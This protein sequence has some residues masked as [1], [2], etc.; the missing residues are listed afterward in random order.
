MTKA[1]CLSL[2]L[3]TSFLFGCQEKV[4]KVVA[5]PEN[6]PK[7]SRLYLAG[8][9]NY[10]DPTDPSFELLPDGKGNYITKLP[11]GW[12]TV[13][14]KVTRGDW[15][16]VE[17]N[18]CGYYISNRTIE[19]TKSDTIN[20]GIESW[21]DLEP[22][23]C[24]RVTIKLNPPKNTKPNEKIYITGSFNNWQ[25]SEQYLLK[26]GKDGKFY[27][28]LRKFKP[29]IEFKFSKGS[30]DSEELNTIGNTVENHRFTFG[31]KDTFNVDVPLWKNALG[32][33][34][35]YV[36]ITVKAPASTKPSEDVYIAGNFNNW[37]TKDPKYK[38]ERVANGFYQIL[39]PRVYATNLTFK[40]CKG[41]WEK[42]EVD[43][44]GKILSDRSLSIGVTDSVFLEIKGWRDTRV[45]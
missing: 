27:I 42:G 8:N 18:A 17:A 29:T 36:V 11:L 19:N 16:T 39:M 26:R 3:F 23:N 24:D 31:K 37:N 35:K 13:N 32:I 30:W 21:D 33:N 15:S 10:W 28:T 5:I 2:L 38:L 34:P 14:Y 7:E 4:I 1:I 43:E 22:V 45:N 12:G 44:L 20:I 41:S 6:T 9:F 25:F 40:F